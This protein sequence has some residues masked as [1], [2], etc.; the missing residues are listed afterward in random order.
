MLQLLQQ[1]LLIIAAKPLPL[2]FNFNDRIRLCD[3]RRRI[4]ALACAV[5]FC[6]AASQHFHFIAHAHDAAVAGNQ[7]LPKIDIAVIQRGAEL[8][9]RGQRFTGGMLLPPFRT[10][11]RQHAAATWFGDIKNHVT[12]ANHFPGILFPGRRAGHH[13]IRAKL[14]HSHAGPTALLQIAQ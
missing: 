1:Y 10:D 9:Q 2:P 11:G 6:R 14:L 7:V 13:Q 5:G 3:N 4:V 12:N 8:L